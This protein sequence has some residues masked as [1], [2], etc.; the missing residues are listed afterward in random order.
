MDDIVGKIYAILIILCGLPPCQEI[1]IKLSQNGCFVSKFPILVAATL[2]PR[3]RAR[4]T[5]KSQ[6]TLDSVPGAQNPVGPSPGLG[7]HSRFNRSGATADRRTVLKL[8]TQLD[9]VS[10]YA[11]PRIWLTESPTS[12]NYAKL[13]VELN[14]TG[15]AIGEMWGE[16]ATGH[17]VFE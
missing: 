3:F 13:C 8:S 11:V 16:L 12:L 5:P 15:A 14:Q 9:L 1:E 2:Q 7:K 6:L 4:M 17:T 10:P